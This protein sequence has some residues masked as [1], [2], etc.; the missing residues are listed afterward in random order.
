MRKIVGFLFVAMTLAMAIPAQAQIKFGIKG[1]LNLAK[2]DFNTSDL[3]ADNFTGFF[4]G[5]MLDVTLPIIGLGVDGALL[6]S[7]QG[8]SYKVK[9]SPSSEHPSNQ[10][11]TIK[12]RGL[13]IPINLKYSIG[14]G[15]LASIYL[16][17]GPSFFFNFSG[18]DKIDGIGDIK[19]KNAEVAIN[20]GGGLKLFKHL[21]IGVN[22]KMPL[23]DSAELKKVS[24]VFD[25]EYKT[26][27]W[28]LSVA[29]MF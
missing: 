22:Y 28:Q 6:Y 26:K 13:D 8:I 4:V 10:D 7:Q 15:S 16:A 2:A 18:D 1:G 3:K 14:L 5:P 9:H 19:M 29:Y 21:Q 27:V 17:A 25:A 11:G 24:D 12:Q 23:S 20:L